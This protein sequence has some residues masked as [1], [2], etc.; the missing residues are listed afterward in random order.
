MKKHLLKTWLFSA[1]MVLGAGS[2]WAD[3]IT[4][5]LVHTS[6]SGVPSA[7]A[8][9][10]VSTIDAEQE[11]I[12]NSA[13]GNKNWQGA[14]YADF[15]FEIPADQSIMKATLTWSGIGS[16][17][18][19]TTDLMYVNAGL[20]LDYSEEGL[21][22]GTAEVNL[23]A[24][25][26]ETVTFPAN[27]TTQFTSDVTDAVKTIAASQAYIIFK[28]TNNIGAGNLVGKGAAS[29]A[30]VLVITTQDASSTTS[31]TVKFVDEGGNELKAAAEHTGVIK[32][33]TVSATAEETASFYSEDNSKKYIYV[34]G[35]S[36]TVVADDGSTVITLV[37][38]EAAVYNY[39]VKT[40]LGT[41]IS[42]GTAFEGDNITYY[43][44]QYQ[45]VDGTLY[46]TAKNN[47]MLRNTTT[48]DTDNKEI[49]VNYTATETTGV[50][51]LT[52]AEDI[53]GA[54]STMGGNADI[55]C[56]MGTGAYFESDAT[57]T[58][59][60]PGKYKLTAQVWGNATTTFAIK[61]G[62]ATVLSIDT[63]GYIYQETSDE[64]EVTESS[65]VT[66]PAVG[67]ANRVL[68]LLY[69]VKTG[70]VAAEN[71]A[72]ILA[73][74]AALKAFE[75]TESGTVKVTLD[76]VK[77][78]YANV[79]EDEYYGKTENVVLED[80]SGADLLQ[81]KGIADKLKAGDVLNGE[82]VL[83]V[84]VDEKWGDVTYTASLDNVTIT[85][86]ELA[87]ME[88]TED[89]LMEYL[90]DYSW[91]LVK[92][93][94]ATISIVSGD[95]SDDIMATIPVMGEDA[96]GLQDTFGTITEWPADGDV[97]DIVGY[98][99]S[100]SYY[101]LEMQYIQPISITK[102]IELPADVTALV[103]A[104]GWK[105]DQGNV[106]A[107][108]KDVAQKEQYLTNTTT[109]E[110]DVL[111]QTVEGLDNG[112]YTVE[113]YANASYTSGRGFT[114]DALN[115]ELGRVVVYAGDVDKTIPVVY[116]TAVGE[117]NIVTLENVVV[118]DGTLKMGL[119]KL[120]PGSNWHT[121]QIKSLTL[122]SL[123]AQADADAQDAYWKGIAQTVAA[124]EAY[125]NV[126]GAEKA[127]IAAAETKDAAE[128]AI[129][130]FY[131]AKTSY[132]ALAEII[133][134]G[135]SVEYDVTEAEALLAAA[136]TTAADA[137]AKAEEL[138][139]PVNLAVNTKAVEGASEENPIETN[140]V[141]NGTFDTAGNTAPWKSTGGFQNQ[142]T[143]TN[144]QGAFTVPFFEN[145]NP[146]AK[147]NKM[148]QEI[149]DI[150]NGNYTLKIAA[151]VNVLADPNESQYVFANGDKTYLTAGEPTAY[152]VNT[153]VTNNKI[154]I[155]LEQTTATANWMGIDNVSLVYRGE[156][157]L[158][159]LVAAYE[160]ALAAA[161]AVEG[162]MNAEVKA[163]LDAAIAAEVDKTNADALGEA[164]AALTEATSAAT[165]SVAA[166]AKAAEVLPKMKE[167]TESTNVYTEEAYE[168]YYNQWV[169]KYEAKTLTTE[170]ANAL[171]DPFVVTG[172]HAAI[173]CDNFLLSAWDTNP[174]FNNAPYYI[175]T[176]SVEGESDGSEFKVPFFE[177]WTGD[178]NSLGEKVLTAK[179]EDVKPDGIYDVTALV[180][181]RV[182]N[183][184]SDAP[185]GITLTVNDGEAVDVTAG[186]QIGTSQ[187]YMKEFVANGTV[188]ADG[189]LT[190]KFNVAADNNISWLSF[191]NIFYSYN[192]ELST[193]ISSINA[194]LNSE[195]IYNLQGQKLQKTV[196]G[197]NIIGGKKIFVK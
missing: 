162:D 82:L 27:T 3:E 122:V 177:Y 120:A 117:N 167:L 180:R 2:A 70:E 100:Y 131:A 87:P 96:I 58:T 154:E 76:N 111:Y 197:L 148:Y 128:A 95:W 112:T 29:G 157:N 159:E 17:K 41:T 15:S 187:F 185:T 129:P 21:G 9:A 104:N 170:E 186:D 69:I 114:S 63:K 110:G 143:A 65:D 91:R 47:N 75:P 6:S 90:G 130:A 145:W 133:A 126:A 178:G 138:K 61:V 10:Y 46:E 72:T 77:V 92:F 36:E 73:N 30:P 119:K 24:T 33:T 71:Q 169:V 136:E 50:V 86:G 85:E 139:H 103:D 101:G 176:W 153:I 194:Q 38:R 121:I 115:G 12:N 158:D 25:K 79:V 45:V 163:A 80:A 164:T 113:L 55:R 54:L 18:N 155:G 123:E 193:G 68:D 81:N 74:I 175:N 16:G 149:E 156:T 135:K 184:V 51:F 8:G 144:Q 142:T 97:V 102:S 109:V 88:V 165:A 181:V 66:I 179:I 116:Q 44:P 48:A 83:T 183:N 34:S 32:G 84:E 188:D 49:V 22:S 118:S 94:G 13:F 23:A 189:I 98:Y 171:Q 107:Y 7:T 52:E 160:A 93:T 14:A 134:K 31:Y 147:V 125:A 105:S 43:F 40:S 35:N 26:I 127:A 191:K 141:V 89:N 57:V 99:V 20:S 161:Q 196:K 137:A 56:S 195:A 78:T 53:E 190:V 174:D 28:F 132:D 5:T 42:E 37:F 172:W 11:Y 67:N 151:F 173:T 108:T 192:E 4:A 182:K 140:F 64:F 19:R 146:S 168:E 166:Y 124:Y 150:P 106:G 152:E 59:L 39:S 62:D 1:L 60:A